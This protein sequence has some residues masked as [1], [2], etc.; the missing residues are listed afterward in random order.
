MEAST[1]GT[2][3]LE[4]YLLRHSSA[5]DSLLYELRR[6]TH[7]TNLHPRMLCGPTQG[8]LLEL[9]CFMFKP[10][11]V[12]E[13]GTYT[14]YSA[15]CMAKGLNLGAEL[16]TIEINDEVCDTAKE[17]FTKAKLDKVITL[18]QGDALDIIPKIE[19]DFDLVLIDGDKRQY[20]QY[21]KVILPRVRVGG[22]I[23][24]DNV[25][26]G[27]KVLL[28]QPDDSFTKGV[29]DF[30][31]MVAENDKLDKVLLPLRDGLSI[32]RKQFE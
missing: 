22:I 31:K 26:W 1:F 29:V 16:H 2:N 17:F 21:L 14:G 18:H 24:A 30:N 8:K 11:R 5:E 23:L 20:P 32:I 12:L 27:G 10:S 6:H 15:I 19:G 3:D 4:E 13:I 7:L 25:L 28:K 9:I